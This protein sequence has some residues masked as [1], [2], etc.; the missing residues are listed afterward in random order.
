VSFLDPAYP[1]FLAAVLAA[2]WL[3][4]GAAAKNLVLVAASATFYGWGEPRMLL[5]LLGSVLLDWVLA[6]AM[7]RWPSR[8]GAL[9]AVSVAAHVVV[10]AV[11]KY[12]AWGVQ[13]ALTAADALG[14]SLDLPTVE[15]LLPL[16][17][18]FYSLQTLGYAIDVHRGQQ[19]A[20]RDLVTYLAFAMF[21]P[22]L[23]AGPIG[24]ARRLFPQLDADRRFSVEA[25]RS[26]LT[27]ALWGAF[28]KVV[29]ADTLAPWVDAI[30]QLPR[31]P[32]VLV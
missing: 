17:I 21:F 18:S 3:L 31:P 11:F 1:V 28:L 27:L 7:E 9:V 32:G 25:L 8:S 15:L 14:V 30:Q 19:R 5:V 22:P 4:P 29:V 26:G 16:G 6:L 20:R 24:R 23:V 12:L 13:S 10:L 2:Y